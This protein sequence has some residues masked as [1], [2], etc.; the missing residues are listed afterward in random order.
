[1]NTA[2]ISKD[3]ISGKFVLSYKGQKIAAAH[4]V[5]YLERVA[6]NRINRNAIKFNIT[7]FEYSSDLISTHSLH[8]GSLPTIEPVKEDLFSIN[9]RF[10]FVEQLTSMIINKTI[11][12]VII[13]GEGGLG[14]TF[15]VLKT[16][17]EAGLDNTQCTSS[18][19]EEIDLARELGD[20][21]VVKG[22]S[23][24][25]GLYRTLFENFDKI[26]IFDDTDSIL[27]NDVALN[28]LKGALDSYDE[29]WISWNSENP[30]SDLPKSFM[31]TGQIIFISN[32]E[33]HRI[34]QAIR[35]RSMCV[36]LS[37]TIDQK[38]ERMKFILANS[39]FL[40]EFANEFK[41]DALSFI[42]L[43][44]HDAVE[45]SLRTLI[46]ITKVRAGGN[47]WE[48]LALYVLTNN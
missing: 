39:E 25:R 5:E 21:T 24:A 34:D 33:Q 13:T 42:E 3:Q 41:T 11:P 40:P 15:T 48:K 7:K 16:I 9:E 29:R 10:E 27:K 45:I 2:T 20:Y 18:E 26:V 44:K 22:F 6:T 36:D 19:K 32:L 46:S 31:F 17:K 1:M 8:T 4:D 12:S 23:T 35:S 47:N 38:I 43:H 14:K 37:M 30:N 28:I